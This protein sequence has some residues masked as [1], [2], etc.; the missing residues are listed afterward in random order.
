M[1][2]LMYSQIHFLRLFLKSIECTSSIFSLHQ[3]LL[4]IVIKISDLKKKLNNRKT[5]LGIFTLPSN[6]SN[7]IHIDICIF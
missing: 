5:K 7:I 6:W 4:Q 2:S 1:G 3:I